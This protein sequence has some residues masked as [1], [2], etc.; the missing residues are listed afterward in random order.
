MHQRGGGYHVTPSKTLCH[1]V[2]KN[3]VGE[4]FGV[5]E[6]FVYQKILCISDVGGITLLRRKLCV[7]Q[8]R[9]ISL[10]NTSVYQK[11]SGIKKFQASERGYHVFPSKTLCHTVPKNFV[12]EHFGV[13]ENFVY[14]KILCISEVGGYHVTPSKT[15][16]HT[17]PKNF[18]GEHF[19]VSENFGYQ[20]IS[21]IREG[22]STLLRRKFCVTQYQKISLLNTS[23]F[24]KILCI[25]KIYA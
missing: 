13:S 10:G 6:N 17:V 16:C 12:A 8:Y 14:Q 15:L 9:K 2:P 18:V 5:S 24:Q 25:A 3:F 11:I 1:T 23:V 19:G 21:S 22:G 4:H 20:K 7:T